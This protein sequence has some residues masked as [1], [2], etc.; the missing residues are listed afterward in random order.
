MLNETAAGGILR[1]MHITV[2]A[3]DEVDIVDRSFI[4]PTSGEE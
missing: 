2:N 3:A 4:C 1:V